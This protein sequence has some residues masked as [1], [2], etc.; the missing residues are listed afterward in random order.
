MIMPRAKSSQKQEPTLPLLPTEGGPPP[1]IA[2]IGRPNV[3][4][5]TLFN[6]ILGQKIAIVDD[7]PG[8]T[9]DRNYADATYRT[10]K[11][12]LVDTGGLD[13]SSSDSM[14]TLIRR[15]SELAI[16]EADILIFLLDGRSGLT[17]P[18]H[19][20]VKL[21][22]GVTKP[23]FYAVNKIDTPKSEPLLAD[24]YKLG[25][26]EL[27]PISAEHGLGVADL[28]DALYPLLPSAEESDELQQ[29]P[30]VAIVGRPNVGK[31]TLVNALL[32]EERVVVSNVPGTT[33]DPVDSLVT[34][35]DQS[36][37]FTDTAGIRRRG[38][39]DRG[40]EGYSVLRS[41][42]AIGRSDIAVLLLDG[43]E[44]V[45]EQDTKIAGA[46]LKQGR[47]CILLINKWDLRAGDQNARQAYELEFHR[48]FPFLAWA[49]VLYGSALKPESIRRLFPLLKDVHGMFTKRVSTGALNIWL[50]KILE[51]H[52]LPARKHKPTAG[53]KSAFMTQVATKP[54]VFVLFVGHP[55][56]IT[57]AYLKYLENQL[58]ETYLFTG[59][60]LRI[61]VRKK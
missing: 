53:T 13:L 50:Q 58:R 24:F 27:Y 2:I 34:H 43:V 48:R 49:P 23:L 61:M 32:G 45:T 29:L 36:Y 28:L 12:R 19:E 4:K 25:T 56:D 20:V 55:E 5:S 14:L 52:P 37:V 8:V 35:Q 18:D 39:I 41:L 1:L 17:P 3:G 15:Q 51:T 59:T 31:S 10:R 40:I 30:R 47:A 57:P 42:R 33:R 16:A 6:K 21:L 44:G 54:P 38:K 9:R 26:D 11:F 46:I 22:R 7:V 60:P